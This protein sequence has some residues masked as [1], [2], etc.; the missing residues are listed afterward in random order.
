M[1]TLNENLRNRPVFICGHPKSGTS[2]L[3]SLMD[4]HPQMIVYPEETI[5]FRKYLPA[6]IG[7][8]KPEQIEIARK[9]LIHIF[10]WN[11]SNPPSTQ[12]GYP[13][14]DY[15]TI[16]MQIVNGEMQR[17]LEEQFR[18]PGDMLSA[19][20]LAYGYA[21]AQ[22]NLNTRYWVE[23]SPYNEYYLDQIL[24]WWQN[25]RF[26][27]IIRDPRDNYA[28]YRRKHADWSP[29]FFSQNWKRSTA[30]G[31][32][33]QTKLGEDKYLI[34]RYE[35]LVHH[36][37][38][39][40]QKLTAFL[41]IDW[42]SSLLQPTRAGKNWGGN[43][44]FND[45]FESISDKPIGRWQQELSPEDTLIIETMSGD[46]MNKF[47]Y[48]SA[49]TENGVLANKQNTVLMLQVLWRVNTWKIRR[50]LL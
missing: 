40:M 18:N 8:D 39:T 9:M 36:P 44:M 31:V 25:A 4:S 34:L 46:L 2:L 22:V 35:D 14:R 45:A 11:T 29:E 15:S 33:N 23:K 3:R 32:E 19:V 13:D 16:S 21:T 50:K 6:I 17:L 38:E 1:E 10:E 7:M 41:V 5:F 48:K 27:H 30:A 24:N 47:G 42:D 26:I 20:I 37:K 12:E 49:F 43:S 28:S